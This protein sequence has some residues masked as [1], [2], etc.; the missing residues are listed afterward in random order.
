VTDRESAL[1]YECMNVEEAASSIVELMENP[2]LAQRLGSSAAH[3]A[4][5]LTWNATARALIEAAMRAGQEA[6]SE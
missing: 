2:E 1:L 3:R 6:R 5:S 4:G